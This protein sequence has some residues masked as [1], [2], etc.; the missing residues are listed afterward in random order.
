MYMTNIKI[1]ADST[2]DLSKELLEAYDI[3]II[4]LYIQLDEKSYL[5]G[6]EITPK[7]LYEWS[8]QCGKTP[9]TAAPGMDV[10]QEILEKYQKE[11]KDLIFFGI[12][13]DMSTTCNVVRLVAQE[14]GYENLYVIDSMNLSTGIGLQVLRAAE[15]A[16]QGMTAQE[17]VSRIEQTREKVRASFVID[18]LTYLHRGGRCSAMTALAAG[19][20]KLKP[21]ISVIG[22]KMDVTKKYRGNIGAVIKKY[23]GDL[24][25]DLKKADPARVFITHSGCSEEVVSQVREYLEGLHHFQE[26]YVTHAGS[27]I[28]SHCGPNTLGV[29]FYEQ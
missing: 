22:G 25:E 8:D 28:S 15:M 18:T 20:L 29:L 1:V 26:I 14:M 10:I 3:T 11:K 12:S 24:E 23:V 27:V 16:S 4:P 21:R 5:D 19:M 17:I 9:K 2:C 13:E 6:L 7:E